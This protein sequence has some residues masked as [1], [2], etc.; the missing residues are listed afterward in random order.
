LITVR[1][2]ESLDQAAP[3]RHDIDTL[4]CLAARPDPFSTFSYLQTYLRHDEQH[5]SGQGMGLWFLTA[6]RDGQLIGYLAL[7]RV[8]TRVMGFR[9]TTVGF[10]VTHDTD[11]PHVVARQSDEVA[12]S[13][14]FYAHLLSRRS[15]WSYLELAQQGACSSL[16]PPPAGVDLAGYLVRQWPSLENCTIPVRWDSLAGYVKAMTKKFRGNL[17]RQLNALF[18]AGEVEL[19]S[20]SDPADTPALLE[21]YLG[22]EPRSWK[23]Q[24]NADIGRHPQRIAYFRSLLEPRQPMRV[25]IHLLL[26]DGVPVA[27]L[28]S[29]AFER[30]L[31][32]LHI[33]YDD[34]LNRLGPGSTMLLLGMR[35]AIEGG[36]AFFN[37]LSGFGYF[38]VR[39]LAEATPLN[40]A[41]IYRRGSPMYWRRRLGDLRRRLMP[42][43]AEGAVPM[44]NP[45]RRA[46]ADAQ[47][48]PPV[49]DAGQ[50]ARMASLIGA[51]RRGHG[52]HLSQAQ[53]AAILP[54]GRG[55]LP[56][57]REGQA[58]LPR[59]P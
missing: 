32:A 16:F 36:F 42:R 27:G 2:Y 10:L 31:Y 52:V 20:S 4:N 3:L 8:E 43:A 34:R 50:R 25:S 33:V 54:L 29:G 38:K 30:S 40:V 18:D 57:G 58:V 23:A 19:L 21:L 11:R 1:C 37:L 46:V 6:L 45:S 22:I 49:F 41:Q 53:L 24:A 47:P 39:W 14:A 7:K 5:P 12:V 15:E 55:R 28:I 35:Q 51:V 17:G 26:M 44:F 59:L 48:P 13:Q 9:S 56:S